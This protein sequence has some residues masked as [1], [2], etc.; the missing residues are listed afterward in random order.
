M[1]YLKLRLR[2]PCFL[3]NLLFK[4]ID[5]HCRQKSNLK[6]LGVAKIVY[7]ESYSSD[8][9]SFSWTVYFLIQ[10]YSLNDLIL[11]IYFLAGWTFILFSP[12][13]LSSPFRQAIEMIAVWAR[14]NHVRQIS[15]FI[16][17]ITNLAPNI[18]FRVLPLL[19]ILNYLA[20]WEFFRWNAFFYLSWQPGERFV[21]ILWKEC[22]LAFRYLRY[23]RIQE[24]DSR[25]DFRL[26]IYLLAEWASIHKILEI[27]PLAWISP[28][29]QATEMEEVIARKR[30][31]NPVVCK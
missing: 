10:I 9:L 20:V 16:R 6:F 31:R 12:L 27:T 17:K 3:W 28:S 11:W 2:D 19:V 21:L 30:V 29:I 24:I 1:R 25:F 14:S 23:F 18:D 22:E 8:L 26:L 15:F 13:C 5:G 4:I 7:R